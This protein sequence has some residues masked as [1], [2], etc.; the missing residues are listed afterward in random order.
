MLT[1][2]HTHCQRC[3]HAEGSVKDYVMQAI[4]DGFDILGMSDH[5][6]YPN[7]DYGYRMDFAE[8]WD[9]IYDVREAQE[10]FGDKLRLLL[11][12]EC[13]YMREY[14]RYYE[15]LLTDYGAE[16][17]V[18]GQHFY[19][20]DGH[21]QSVHC[22]DN[23]TECLA[24][25]RSIREGLETGWYSLLAHPDFVGLNCLPWDRNMD[26]MTDMIIDSAVKNDV[27]LE[28]NANGVRRGIVRD[29]EGEHYGYTHFR[30]WE[31]VAGSGAKV[32]IS[33]DCHNPALL[34]DSDV[35]KCRDIAKNWGLDVIEELK[36]KK[37]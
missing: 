28:I 8:L 11:G 20:I 22:I 37:Q 27:P 16:Y 18:L 9:Y 6:P 30:F 10:E 31:K 33:A 5:L 19:D 2:Y 13:E 36:V 15:E 23:T 25:A 4:R 32:V 1:N 26:E 14:R 34:N 12:F 17:L 21:W 7:Y 3:K 29:S 35:Q 24:Y